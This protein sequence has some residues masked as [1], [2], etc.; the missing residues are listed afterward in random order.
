MNVTYLH[1]FFSWVFPIEIKHFKSYQRYVSFFLL[2]FACQRSPFYIKLF[3]SVF[4]R[5]LVSAADI[6]VKRQN[7]DDD[8]TPNTDELCQDRPA[9][10]YFRASLEGDCRDV[11]R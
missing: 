7:D 1:N 11:V 5:L 6:R 3:S 10:E 9:D 2:G 4:L 8:D